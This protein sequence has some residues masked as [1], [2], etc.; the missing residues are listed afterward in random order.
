MT[1][2]LLTGLAL[3]GLSGVLALR[4]L[5][6][7]GMRRRQALAH[8]DAYGFSS[9]A[10]PARPR[11]GLRE[12]AAG[13]ASAVGARLVHRIGP[14]RER[15]LQTVLDSAGFYGTSAATFLGYR[16]LGA[17]ALP[18]LALAFGAA[19]G[20]VSAR[21]ILG[22]AFLGGL[23]WVMPKFLL[24]RKAKNRLAEVDREVP[25]LVDLLVT[26]VEAGVGFGAA[27]QLAARSIQGPL[28]QE[29]RL[30]LHEQTMGLTTDEA[31]RN[32]AARVDSPAIRAFI[33]ALLQGE[34][35]GVSIGKVLR[36]LAVDMR[37][38][39]RQAAEERA[40]KAPT[41]IL[42]P[43]VLLILPAMFIVTLGP[44]AVTIIRVLGSS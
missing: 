18:V 43:L 44:V 27:L 3:V 28:G 19:G 10:H 5:G 23:G 26:T 15:Q 31:L 16:A 4:T 6:F 38:R 33:Q 29:L 13:V 35:L 14:E 2:L 21:G 40:Q 32:L 42:F 8:I 36:D 41:K 30:A 20:G 7:A 22:A 37:K 12:V 24:E 1:F 17:T 39:R 11:R 25:E 9:A 34:A